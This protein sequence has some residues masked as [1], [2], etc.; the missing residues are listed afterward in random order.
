[1][2]FLRHLGKSVRLKPSPHTIR[3]VKQSWGSGG[4]LF[5]VFCLE[6]ISMNPILRPFPHAK[7]MYKLLWNS[8]NVTKAYILKVLIKR[9]KIK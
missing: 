1:M 5:R 8:K 4:F 9:E 2:T 3:H 7:T 6:K